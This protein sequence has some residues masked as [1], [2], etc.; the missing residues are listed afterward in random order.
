VGAIGDVEGAPLIRAEGEAT[1]ERGNA[2]LDGDCL[3]V[4]DAEGDRDELG[5]E[6][7]VAV[8]R[9]VAVRCRRRWGSSRCSTGHCTPGG[10]L[11][12]LIEFG[13]VTG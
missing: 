11:T 6:E 1:E 5:L 3:C 2:E 9:N 7:I 4:G 10:R 13:E 12:I 8:L